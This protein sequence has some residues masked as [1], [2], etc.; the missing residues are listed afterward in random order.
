MESWTITYEGQNATLTL[1][2]ETEGDLVPRVEQALDNAGITVTR[3]GPA[4][5]PA[6]GE[7]PVA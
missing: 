6:A 5:E 7:E 1:N 3:E 4:E 2:T